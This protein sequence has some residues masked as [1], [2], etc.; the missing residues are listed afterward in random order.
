MATSSRY[1]VLT[2]TDNLF[3]DEIKRLLR[4][5]TVFVSMCKSNSTLYD[6]K[7]CE[8]GEIHLKTMVLNGRRSDRGSCARL[9][10]DQNRCFHRQTRREFIKDPDKIARSGRMFLDDNHSVRFPINTVY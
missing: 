6:I 4:A 1:P 3:V 8:M 7:V 10:H 9:S 2:D 5:A